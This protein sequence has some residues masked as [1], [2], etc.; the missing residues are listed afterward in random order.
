MIRKIFIA[1]AILLFSAGVVLV[2]SNS[3]SWADARGEVRQDNMVLEKKERD[4]IVVNNKCYRVSEIT[5]IR[6]ISGETISL[7]DLSFPVS[8]NLTY[9]HNPGANIFEVISAEVLGNPSP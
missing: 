8:A 1:M 2:D 6:G 4:C 5:I 9:Y 3:F 7:S